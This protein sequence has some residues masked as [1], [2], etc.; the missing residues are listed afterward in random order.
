MLG[1]HGYMAFC[2]VIDARNFLVHNPYMYHVRENLCI[3]IAV[4]AMR[5][6][7][8][9]REFKGKQRF[10]SSEVFS[11]DAWFEFYMMSSNY[12][13]DNCYKDRFESLFFAR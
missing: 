13:D 8:H 3:F 11:D 4:G 2:I 7:C 10:D 9:A 12:S 5:K 6:S 1:M